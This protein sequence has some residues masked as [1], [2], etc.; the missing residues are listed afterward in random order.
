M[1]NEVINLDFVDKFHTKSIDNATKVI[2]NKIINIYENDIE[3]N[4]Q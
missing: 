1:N 2:L 4:F 3:K